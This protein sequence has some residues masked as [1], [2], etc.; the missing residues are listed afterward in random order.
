MSNDTFCR[1]EELSLRQFTSETVAALDVM[2]W[3]KDA[4]QRLR[5][6]VLRQRRGRGTTHYIRMVFPETTPPMACI[7]WY[8]NE[9]SPMF[10]GVDLTGDAAVMAQ[11]LITALFLGTDADRTQLRDRIDTK[12]VPVK[13][14]P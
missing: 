3:R 5:N 7:E 1:P 2:S 12:Y 8:R 11:S 4:S 14:L 13:P 10:H 9:G 6:I